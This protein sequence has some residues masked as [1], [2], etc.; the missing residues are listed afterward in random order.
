VA[1]GELSVPL[2]FGV[3]LGLL[4]AG[5]AIFAL[6]GYHLAQTGSQVF[7]LDRDEIPGRLGAHLLVFWAASYFILSLAYSLRLKTYPIMDVL[8]IAM[9]FV[10]RAMAG[11]AAIAVV[12]SPWLV[13]CT[14][15]LCL[16]IALAKRRSEIA[17][18]GEAARSTRRVNGFYTLVNIEHMLAVS[19]GLA[20]VTYSLYCLAQRT[21]AR[22]SANLVW[23]IPLVVYGMFRYYC[24]A[25]NSDGQDV[26]KL[27]ARDRVMWMVVGLWMIF[28]VIIIRFGGS[29]IFKGIL[30]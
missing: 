21:I 8:I 26:A 13:V 18:L 14:F 23:T 20:I 12:I 2:A 22:H 6:I 9:G 5:A 25:L 28:V 19:A 16:F 27:L 4:L 30:Q 15:T 1:S 10:L 11:A 24:L 17:I 7:V 29:P 3:A